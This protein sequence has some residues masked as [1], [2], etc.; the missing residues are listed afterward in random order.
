M[1]R[2]TGSQSHINGGFSAAEIVVEGSWCWQ[3]PGDC[4]P[5]FLFL[6][7][8]VGSS[9]LVLSIALSRAWLRGVWLAV[10]LQGSA[11]SKK[12]IS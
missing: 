7:L 1:Q 10:W 5:R 12:L 4:S 9:P 6:M 8:F 11:G 2:A 3:T